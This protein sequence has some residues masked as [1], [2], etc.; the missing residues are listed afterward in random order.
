MFGITHDKLMS[1]CKAGKIPI[2]S[3]QNFT[4]TEKFKTIVYWVSPKGGHV[5]WFVPDSEDSQ[6]STSYLIEL[7]EKTSRSGEPVIR[8]AV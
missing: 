2:T 6:G 7:L 3:I 5:G 4:G 1:V 8:Q